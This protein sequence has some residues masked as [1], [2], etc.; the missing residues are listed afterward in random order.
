MDR[1]GDHDLRQNKSDS[2][3]GHIS[4]LIWNP[5]IKQRETWKQKGGCLGRGREMAG[6]VDKKGKI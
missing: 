4:P 6:E 3:R 5:D 1:A 2:D